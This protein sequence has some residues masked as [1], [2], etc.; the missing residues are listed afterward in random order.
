[1]NLLDQNKVKGKSMF[2]PKEIPHKTTYLEIMDRVAKVVN[3]SLKTASN[4]L[5]NHQTTS[6]NFI[7]SVG[8]TVEY[9][10]TAQEMTRKLSVNESIALDGGLVYI[11]Y[12]TN[13]KLEKVLLRKLEF[14]L[15]KTIN[16]PEELNTFITGIATL[17]F[18]FD[19]SKAT[20]EVEKIYR[21][22]PILIFYR[23]RE[24]FIS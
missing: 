24:M 12:V 9:E 17:T 6:V 14:I 11:D 13:L 2:S 8:E 21:D 5:S 7:L 3:G 19:N 10:K 20:G 1:M 15:A 4:K 16:S 22:N 23:L 18:L